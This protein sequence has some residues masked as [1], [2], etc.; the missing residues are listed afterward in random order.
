MLPVPGFK[1]LQ[2]M[3]K[4]LTQLRVDVFD[5]SSWDIATSDL[6]LL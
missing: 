4:P 6:E 5:L 1:A 3:A 2:L